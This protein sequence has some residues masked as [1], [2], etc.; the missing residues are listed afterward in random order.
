MTEIKCYRCGKITKKLI[1]C[2]DGLYMGLCKDCPEV[3][4]E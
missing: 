1:E 4:E 3:V 2:P